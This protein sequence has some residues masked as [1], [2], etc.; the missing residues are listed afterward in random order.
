MTWSAI[1]IIAIT[2]II[3]ITHH[4]HYPSSLLYHLTSGT[5][6]I[7]LAKEKVLSLAMLTTSSSARHLHSQVGIGRADE[8]LYFCLPLTTFDIN[9]YQHHLR[10]AVGRESSIA[11]V[12]QAG[13]GFC[14]NISLS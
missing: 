4:H 3:I 5:E 9:Q 11:S 8:Y 13:L 12:S 14:I 7:A 10:H 6:Q 1:I 2:I